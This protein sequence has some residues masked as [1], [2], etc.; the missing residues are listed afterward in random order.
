MFSRR[1]LFNALTVAAGGI[2]MAAIR[3][4]H[5]VAIVFDDQEYLN[6][7]KD[8]L[9]EHVAHMNR[10]DAMQEEARLQRVAEEEIVEKYLT[11]S[12]RASALGQQYTNEMPMA[13]YDLM[14]RRSLVDFIPDAE[15][16]RTIPVMFGSPVKIVG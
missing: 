12:S 8:R 10:I 6:E 5:A 15:G 11:S 16:K 14:C 3:T 2:G 7:R 4:D 9:A 1:K 13:H